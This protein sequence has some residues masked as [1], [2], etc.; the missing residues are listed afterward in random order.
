MSDAKFKWS[1]QKTLQESVHASCCPWL[2]WFRSADYISILTA[3]ITDTNEKKFIDTSPS[4][5]NNNMFLGV[6][7]SVAEPNFRPERSA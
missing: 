1:C 4:L 6:I 3:A 2:F 7:S 5:G